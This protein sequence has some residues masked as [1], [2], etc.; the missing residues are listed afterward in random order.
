MKT[1]IAI[2]VLPQGV[3]EEKLL[4]IVD[5]CI[6]HIASKGLNYEVDPFET[7]IEGDDPDELLDIVKELQSIV[8]ENGAT[9]AATYVKFWYS[10]EGV[11]TIDEK[12]EKHR[13]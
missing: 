12:T 11:L 8:I 9:G 7:V 4:E 5:K 2:Q 13:H 1:S 6:E 3:G 10:P